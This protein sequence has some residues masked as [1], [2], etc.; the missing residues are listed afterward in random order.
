M[1]D[2]NNNNDLFK[3]ECV[4]SKLNNDV[5]TQAST[6]LNYNYTFK[7]PNTSD[8][9]GGSDLSFLNMNYFQGFYSVNNESQLKS[10]LL[11]SLTLDSTCGTISNE[12]LFN[13]N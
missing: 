1:S 2:K 6:P 9:S 11:S 13:K 12:N 7:K 5:A 3:L 10:K 8:V 4:F